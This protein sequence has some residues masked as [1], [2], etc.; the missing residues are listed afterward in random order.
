MAIVLTEQPTA[1]GLYS[2]YLPVK[3]VAR[4]TANNPAYL[5]FSLRTSAGAAIA[6]VPNYIAA[7]INNTYTFDA[8]SYLKSILNVLTTQGFS[9]TAIEELTD[10]YG[11][12]E[13]VVKD[14]IGS[15]TE[16]RSNE[17]YAFAN[18]DGLRYA[19][20]QTANDGI[21]RKGLLYASEISSGYYAPKFQGTYDRVVLF[22][23]TVGDKN[24]YLAVYTYSEYKPNQSSSLI[25]TLTLDLVANRDK[26]IS[27]PINKT[28]IDAN[29]LVFGGGAISSYNSFKLK[30]LGSNNAMF[31]Y[32]EDRCNITEFMFINKYGVKENIKF[33]TYTYESINTKSDSYRVGGYTHTGNIYDFN[34]SANNVKINQNILEDYEVRGQMFPTKHIGELHDFVASPL[35][36]LVDPRPPRWTAEGVSTIPELIAVNVL[37]GGFKMAVKSRGVEFNFKYRLAQTKPSFI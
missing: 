7:N 34:T 26:L 36:W 28:F 8:S 31:Y 5:T 4:E 17:F 3:F 13:V 22:P 20:D 2:A 9:T 12:Y 11:K 15:L 14:T 24:P 29:F 37:D 21:N 25:Q 18:I 23:Q 30:R 27:V 35:H 6:N 32:Y 16:L 1:D 33:Q 19:N 10:L